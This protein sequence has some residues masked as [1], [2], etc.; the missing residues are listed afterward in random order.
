M[1]I[2]SSF[3]LFCFISGACC[4][5]QQKVTDSLDLIAGDNTEDTRIRIDAM[6]RLSDLYAEIDKDR[7][8][9]Y[10][11]SAVELSNSL[12]DAG[13]QSLSYVGVTDAGKQATVK[14]ASGKELSTPA[15]TVNVKVYKG[16][17]VADEFDGEATCDKRYMLSRNY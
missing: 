7:T 13:C 1:R 5:G 15:L 17:K 4:F 10:A 2:L 14:D 12:K 3:V 9:A 16:G 6:I 8:I 11:K